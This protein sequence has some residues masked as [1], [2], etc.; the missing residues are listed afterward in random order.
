MFARW[1]S[2]PLLAKKKSVARQWLAQRQRQRRR[3]GMAMTLGSAA[4]A[5]IAAKNKK[6]AHR[7]KMAASA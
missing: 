3:N 6:P 1:R 4:S 5:I 2:A 7:V